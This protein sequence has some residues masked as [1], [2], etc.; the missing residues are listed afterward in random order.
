MLFY[1]K[2]KT[3]ELAAALRQMVEYCLDEGQK[4]ADKAGYIPLPESV[5]EKVR[6]AS[7]NIQ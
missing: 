3:P 5:V 2:N 6:A 4:I 1:K 7:K